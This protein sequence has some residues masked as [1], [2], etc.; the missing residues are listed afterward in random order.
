MSLTKQDTCILLKEWNIKSPALK[1]I[2]LNSQKRFELMGWIYLYKDT[3]MN[4][5]EL[6]RRLKTYNKEWNSDLYKE[7][8]EKT[9]LEIQQMIEP[10][11][12]EEGAYKCLKCGS[13]RTVHM[14]LQI[15]SSDEGMTNFITCIACNNHWRE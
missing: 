4:E 8:K 13:K 3:M 1:R 9:F 2:I 11:Q 5:K 14:S 10:P 7:K 12:V 6:L 15:R